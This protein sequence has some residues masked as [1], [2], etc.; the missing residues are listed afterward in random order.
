MPTCCKCCL[1]A[2]VES[3]KSSS[4]WYML[5]YVR[6]TTI[7]K[8]TKKSDGMFY[9]CHSPSSSFFAPRFH[10]G[11]L[12]IRSVRARVHSHH[13][14]PNRNNADCHY[15]GYSN[16]PALGVCFQ[17]IC[18]VMVLLLLFIR[19]FALHRWL[20]CMPCIGERGDDIGKNVSSGLVL[21]FSKKKH[22]LPILFS[23]R[24][25]SMSWM[26]LVF[27]GH[28]R[29]GLMGLAPPNQC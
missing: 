10:F 22:P 25:L 27:G 4:K 18:S 20:R 8:Y 7:I 1:S 23:I 6:K 28:C 15:L 9:I 29:G 11:S 26:C 17:P 5:F 14:S 13:F 3:N 19:L 12:S 21:A 24:F 16:K 2:V